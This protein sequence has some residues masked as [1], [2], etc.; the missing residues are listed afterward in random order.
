MHR[1]SL[2]LQNENENLK[3]HKKK[4]KHEHTARVECYEFKTKREG[5]KMT[6]LDYDDVDFR[7]RIVQVIRSNKCDSLKYIVRPAQV[8]SELG[9][10]IDDANA[11]LCGL[12]RA[13]GPSATFEFESIPIGGSSSSS[14]IISSTTTTTSA[15]NMVFHF[16]INFARKA[17]ITKQKEHVKD[18]LLNFLYALFKLFKVIVAFGLILSILFVM[19][20]TILLMVAFVIA[21]ARMNNQNG[22]GGGRTGHQMQKIYLA[23][24]F[25]QYILRQFFWMYMIIRGFDQLDGIDSSNGRGGSMDPFFVDVAYTLAFLCNPYSYWMWFRLMNRRLRRERITRGWRTIYMRSN[26]GISSGGGCSSRHAISQRR[27]STW[28][29]EHNAVDD[30]DTTQT[31]LTS[32]N[33]S[34]SSQGNSATSASDS[35]DERGL[36]SNAVEFLFGPTP[37]HPGPNDF[38]KWKLR[39]HFIVS[40][41]IAKR[42]IQNNLH[43]QSQHCCSKNLYQPALRLVEL[44]PFVDHP[45]SDTLSEEELWRNTTMRSECLS[46]VTHFNGIPFIYQ[47]NH[48]E[49]AQNVHTKGNKDSFH[50]MFAFPEL[51]SLHAE[52]YPVLMHKK[53]WESDNT[54]SP[55][56]SFLYNSDHTTNNKADE[57]A[58]KSS[59][60]SGRGHILG[61]ESSMRRLTTDSD[62]CS[63]EN[64]SHSTPLSPSPQNDDDYNTYLT[65]KSYSFTKLTKSQF[66]QCIQMNLVNYIA[67]RIFMKLLESTQFKAMQQL[68]LTKQVLQSIMMTLLIYAKFFFMLPLCRMIVLLV[69]NYQIKRR[70]FRRKN[71]A[72]RFN[73]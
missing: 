2:L 37:F 36:L 47:H 4:T 29:F 61:G 28:N 32:M 67:L 55:I 39:E 35:S 49:N 33:H 16:P 6:L 72:V 50:A 53:E 65:E 20:Y 48:D 9:I 11:E 15:T 8:A 5:I 30:E 43:D 21:M 45:P 70:N 14:E 68:P 34:T 42:N 51:M 56:F 41:I 63:T 31:L 58:N 10:S 12:M 18:T 25:I 17:Y 66:Y 64:K 40:K 23:I 3:I 24:R 38:T 57:L 1:K 19:I 13:V 52:N 73:R 60:F 7:T 27:D 26:E 44:L 59:T 46:I 54:K 69:L 22:R 71:F 62:S